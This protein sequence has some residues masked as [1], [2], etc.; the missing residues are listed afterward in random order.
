MVLH[1][2]CVGGSIWTPVKTARASDYKTSYVLSAT[3]H[4]QFLANS[5]ISSRTMEL[6]KFVMLVGTFAHLTMA[7]F[8]EGVLCVP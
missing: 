3:L 2:Q 6:L 1:Q 5:L 8:I 4:L 7:S